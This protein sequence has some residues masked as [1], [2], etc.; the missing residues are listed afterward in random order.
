MMRNDDIINS[1]DQYDMPHLA[2]IGIDSGNK[3]FGTETKSLIFF[4]NK[5]NS[6]PCDITTKNSFEYFRVA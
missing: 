2:L 4:C 1:A 5:I 6:K 3:D